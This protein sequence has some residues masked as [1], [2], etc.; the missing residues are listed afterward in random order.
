M[1][2]SGFVYMTPQAFTEKH[3]AQLR[4]ALSNLVDVPIVQRHL[5]AAMANGLNW[6]DGFAYALEQRRE[7]GALRSEL[8]SPT[9]RTSKD[10]PGGNLASRNTL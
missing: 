8:H 9:Q 3:A 6:C 2:S 4:K 7:I 1:N 5:K 10:N